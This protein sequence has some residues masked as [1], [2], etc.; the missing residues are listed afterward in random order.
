MAASLTF[1][2]AYSIPREAR[3]NPSGTLLPLSLRPSQTIA[4][5]SGA[6]PRPPPKTRTGL[7][8]PS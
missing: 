7:A 1:P 4:S 8:V 3:K 2:F 5:G 6:A